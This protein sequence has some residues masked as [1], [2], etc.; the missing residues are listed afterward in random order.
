MIRYTQLPPGASWIAEYGDPADPVMRAAILKYSPYQNLKAETAY[1]RVFFLTSTKDDRVNPA[2]ARK[3][4]AAMEG[5]GKPFYYYEETE[6]GHSA[7]A[8]LDQRAKQLALQYVYLRKQ[9]MEG[10]N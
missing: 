5:M 4:A 7:A 1:P 2:H 8:N 6:G 3:M 9:L 10:G